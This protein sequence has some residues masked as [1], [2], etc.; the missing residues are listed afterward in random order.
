MQAALDLFTLHGY[1][2]VS[3]EM[4]TE[5]ADEST[6]T[7]Y[8]YFKSKVDIYRSLT[9]EAHIILIDIMK[10]AVSWPGM[11]CTAKIS[12]SIHAYFRFYRDY[13]GYYKILNILHIDQPDFVNDARLVDLVNENAFQI[14]QFLSDIIKEGIDSGEIKITDPWLSTTTIWGMIDGILL[15]EIRKDMHIPG[16][17]LDVLVKSGLDIILQGLLPRND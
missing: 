14:L 8:L 17:D 6:G 10:E 1:Q 2:S 12:A 5:K 4:I 11:N 15:M 16:V 3:I 9:M 13:L 7:F